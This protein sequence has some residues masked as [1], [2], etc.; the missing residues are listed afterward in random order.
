[1]TLRPILV[2]QRVEFFAE[3][4]ERRDALDQRW[5]HFLQSCGMLAIPLPNAAGLLD[6]YLSIPHCCGAVLTGGNEPPGWGEPVPE[7]DALE[8]SLIAR[9]R[10]GDFPLLGVC[11]GMQM[12]Q[13]AL[14]LPLK[15]IHGHIAAA[16]EITVDG[17]RETV[18]SYHTIGTHSTAP[19]TE[20][21]ATADDGVV[22]ALRLQSER[23]VG[24]MWHPERVA[25]FAQRDITLFRRHFLS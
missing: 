11:R 24:I 3:R 13:H 2:S 18:N 6:D 7:R 12:I 21:W 20:T 9:A 4:G 15:R 17:V 23:V 10:A 14:G 22:K 16:Q 8:G 19:E 5:V 25:P 1:M